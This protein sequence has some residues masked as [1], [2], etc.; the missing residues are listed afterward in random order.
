[1]EALEVTDRY[2]VGAEVQVHFD[3][4]DPANA[5]LEPGAD[6][7]TYGMFA[8]AGAFAFLAPVGLFGLLRTSLR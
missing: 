2:P 4:E 3:P 5:V 8:I 6:A 1:M 7:S